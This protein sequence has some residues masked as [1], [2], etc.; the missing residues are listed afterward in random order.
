MKSESKRNMTDALNSLTFLI[1]VI[2]QTTGT[3][4]GTLEYEARSFSIIALCRR[5]ESKWAK[6]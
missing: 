4:N 6:I 2:T 1:L 3:Q 5:I